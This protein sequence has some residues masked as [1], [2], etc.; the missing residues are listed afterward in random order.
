MHNEH[1]KYFCLSTICLI[2][3]IQYS[4]F[5]QSIL[6]GSLT[7]EN[8]LSNNRVF[9]MVQDNLGFLWFGT[10]DG[11]NR[12]DGYEIKVYRNDPD[13]PYSISDNSIRSLFV[14]KSGH[15]WIG[16]K[17]GE[18]NRYDPVSDR[19]YKWE[20]NSMGIKENSITCIYEDHSGVIWFGTYKDG[21]YRFVIEENKFENWTNEAENS[22]S[23]SINYVTSI[24][25]DI[26]S[27]LFIST[28]HGLN[29]FNHF[30]DENTFERYYSDTQSTNSLSDNL[31]WTMEQSEF[32]PDIIWIGTLNGLTEFKTNS[33]EFVRHKLPE[34]DELQFGHSISS[35]C[36]DRIGD[37]RTLW[38]G[39][40]GGLIKKNLS[41]GFSQRFTHEENNP[42]SINSNQIHALLKDR[43][44]VVWIA[45]DNGLNYFSPKS[46]KF[47]YLSSLQISFNSLNELFKKVVNPITRSPDGK[48]WFGTNE[49]LYFIYESFF[50]RKK[51]NTFSLSSILSLNNIN[52]W[53]LA[54]DSSGNLWIGTYG[55]GLKQLNIQ[56]NELRSWEIGYKDY[57]LISPYKYIKSLCSASNN[58]LWI[59]YWGGGVARVNTIT[60]EY[61]IWRNEY[62]LPGE[63][64]YNDVW[65][66]H[67]DRLGRIWIGTNGGGLNLFE[68]RDGGYFHQWGED[69]SGS[70]K[71]LNSNSIYTIYESKFSDENKTILWIGTRNGLNKFIVHSDPTSE[72]ENLRVEIKNYSVKDGLPDN[73]VE[74]I[75]EDDNGNLWIGTGSG[76]S[77]FN[78]G[79]ELFKNYSV[80]DGLV[81]NQFNT[82]ASFKSKD[83][84]IFLA[85]SSGLNIF[86][87]SKIKNSDYQPPVL[88]T[89][90]MIF[91]LP[92]EPKEG[93]V[94]NSNIFFSKEL[95]LSYTQNVF[96]FQFAALDF[97]SPKSNQ[98]AYKME[99]FDNEW[100]YSNS[101]RFVTYTNLD[102][103]EYIFKVKA[104]NSDG[105][106]NENITSLKVI[107]TPPIWA[108]WYAYTFYALVFIG[109]L[110]YIR[111]YEL[112][113]RAKKV[114]ERLRKQKAEAEIREMKL[115]AEAAELKAITL[116]QEKEIEKQKIRN[117][118]ARDL[119]DEI[120]SNL[121]SISLL[122]RMLKDELNTDDKTIDSLSRIESTAKNSVTSIRDIVWFIN[123]SSD[124]LRDLILKM[125]EATENL[126]KGKEFCF[127]QSIPEEDIKITP[128][129]KRAIYLIHKETLNNIVKHSGADNVTISITVE[130]NRFNLVI[131]DNGKGYDVNAIKKGNG[132]NNIK[133]RASEINADLAM[134]SSP[135]S[136][137]TIELN[138]RIT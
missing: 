38:I 100:I 53:S 135:G 3:L 19:F 10:D 35:I 32:N 41:T 97:N 136:G 29:R 40:F 125:K 79:N 127:N 66:L 18:L 55:H 78:V 128:E 2:L 57:P 92:V 103:G 107:I 119:H 43:S 122:S 58:T 5:S 88:I 6:F 73:S 87:P 99:G 67:E 1:Y 70:T 134:L 16:T 105:I 71:G 56:T 27:N 33:G 130:D 81:G 24:L 89:G 62:S 106:W 17:G 74:C 80:S 21:L 83:G 116:E 90:L 50:D 112:E 96:S 129:V 98:Y 48:L 118:I 15:I 113:K 126:L 61:K 60:G 44:G 22:S 82:G 12:F 64:S 25:E 93:T 30:N 8:G 109:V 52:V 123:P 9:C 131:S 37:D 54:A 4:G 132:L 75:V 31:I 28:F 46:I 137:S 63:L 49:G 36:E 65:A 34:K 115:K 7:T 104:T 14:D 13:N 91:N 68:D 94:L 72:Y 124:S 20:I 23:L 51:S 114:S 86:H 85:S 59:G 133:S 138:L 102:P 42:F 111:K 101:R 26:N 120:G 45:S 121:S 77:F 47:N 11:L 69:K 110:L 95:V 108:T 117:R 84:L 76:I 39:T